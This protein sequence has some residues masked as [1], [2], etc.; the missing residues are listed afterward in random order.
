M[1]RNS[2]IDIQHI[3]SDRFEVTTHTSASF[4]PRRIIR[5]GDKAPILGSVVHRLEGIRH[6]IESLQHVAQQVDRGRQLS[7]RVLRLHRRRRDRDVDSL[8]AHRVVER[9]ARHIDVYNRD[10]S[11]KT[12]RSFAWG[13]RLAP[14]VSRG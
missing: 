12:H 5:R 2:L 14:P 6:V 13:S 7:L 8:R 1:S 4:L 11:R 10:D 9:H 3:I